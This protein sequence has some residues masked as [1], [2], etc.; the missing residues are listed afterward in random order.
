MTRCEGPTY[1]ELLVAP[2]EELASAA[3]EKARAAHGYVVTTPQGLHSADEALPRRCGYCTFAQ[4][5]LTSPR[6][7]W[8][9]T[10]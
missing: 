5:R 6:P 3:F 1:S 9:W 8:V 10:K 4:A 2:L 7:T